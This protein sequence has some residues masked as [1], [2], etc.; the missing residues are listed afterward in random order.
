MGALGSLKKRLV[1]ENLDGFFVSKPANVSYLSAFSGHES[2]LLI[3]Q[4]EDFFITDFRYYRQAKIEIKDFKIE[5]TASGRN[6]LLRNHFDLIA[7]LIQKNRLNRVGFEAKHITYGEVSRIR[8]R[9]T[10]CEFS[11]TY[12]FV[13]D[14]RIIKTPDE[15]KRI[16]TAV[17]IATV[18]LTDVRHNI[19][20]GDKEKDL[21]AFI[22]YQMRM[23]GAE[24]ASFD[25]IVLSG[26]NSVMP[27]GEPSEK[28]ISK[29]EIILIDAGA[30]LNGY[31]SDLTRVFF[32]G[33][34]PA[35]VRRIYD[36]VKKAQD[37]AIKAIKPG[38]EACAV[39]AVARGYIEKHG[40]GKYF[41]HSLGHGI[42]RE[43]HEAPW[44]SPKS[45]TILKPGMV[46]TVEPAVYAPGLG[47][48]RLEEMVLVKDRGMEV[49][50]E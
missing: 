4:N 25:I 28:T 31:N 1:K 32:L 6:R 11:P 8:D 38:V 18:V 45:K 26:I 22:E 30:R 48:I 27:H 36:V 19:K 5:V 14:I 12:D 20:P 15:V 21:A 37:L 50:S 34:I 23:R 33:K 40:W 17:K 41:R 39:D 43:V 9:L 42:G 47:G 7:G 35:V 49:L 46:I 10:S 2:Y 24:A 29:N 3:T 44:L 16:K 13:E